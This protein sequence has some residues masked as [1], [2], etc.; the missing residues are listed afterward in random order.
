MDAIKQ[1]FLGVQTTLIGIWILVF[2]IP[3]QNANG[4]WLSVI[5]LLIGTIVVGSALSSSDS[6]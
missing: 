4:F 6:S 2:S 5:F 3:T 1:A